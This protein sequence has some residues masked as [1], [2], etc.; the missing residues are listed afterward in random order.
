MLFCPTKHWAGS[1]FF[2]VL[3]LHA[4]AASGLTIY[5]IGGENFP[6]PDL[7]TPYEF[8]QI[9]WSDIDA[10]QHG[11][12]S[13]IQL[14]PNSIRPQ[15]LSPDIN[16]TP[17]IKE[18]GGEVL[19]F[20]WNGWHS[21][22]ELD[23]LM[24]DGD[25][26]TAFLGDGRFAVHWPYVKALTFDLGAPLLLD[27]I[28]FFPRDKH[29]TDR[30]LQ[31]FRI[32]VNDGDP[33][34][35]G[36]REVNLGATGFYFDFDIVYDVVENTQSVIDLTFP[37]QPIRYVLFYSKENTTG[38]WE[39]AEL[40]IYGNG[41]APFASYVSNVIDLGAPASLGSLR[42]AG[43]QDEGATLALSTRSGHDDDPNTYWR[44]TF[45]GGER[46]RFDAKGRPL[47][48]ASYN[49]LALGAQAG[50]THDTAGWT[51]W[52]T[53][54]DFAAGEG[55]IAGAG[56][57]Q[58]VQ[59]RADFTSG[60]RTS[61]QF[62]WVELAVSIPPVAQQ[63]VA[64]VMP[65][66]VPPGAATA[67]TYKVK[68]SIARDDLGFDRLAIDTPARV[69]S[70]DGVRL[71]GQPVAFD[72]V[73]SNDT[74]VV[75]AV[76][77]VDVQ[78]TQEVLE[79]AF[80]ASVFQFGTVF[81]GHIFNS[82][83]PSEVP[84]SLAWGDADGVPSSERLRVDLTGLG[85]GPLGGLSVEPRVFSPNGDRINDVVEIGC[86][87]L[88][89]SGMSSVAC[90]VYDVSGRRLGLV[91]ASRL[92]SGRYVGVWDG[93]DED[94]ALL[95]PGLYVVGLS[96]ETNQGMTQRQAVVSLVY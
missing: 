84:Q 67:F 91:D 89:L 77:L 32:G 53:A 3:L 6:P 11:R 60:Q 27:R 10:A 66:V 26:A 5:R 34:K 28:R 18:R 1:I 33:L 61:G 72:I 36:T 76:P 16:L 19:N 78:R 20:V 65:S 71:S 44:Y 23:E 49:K 88:N 13:L 7:D 92:G 58:F 45:R 62:D 40:E 48:L 86:D 8:V 50:F 29:L 80:H 85:T 87:V 21:P 30:F 12:E 69:Q 52:S 94:G 82:Q 15:F 68:A 2:A 17:L 93:R 42:W 75:L 4:P 95:S 38:I 70:V 25:L 51:F 64:E 31:Q 96:V 46:T 63:A 56:P 57:R 9:G 79:V 83:H 22:S 73:Q 14:D 81:T 43:Q 54:Q 47:N 41:F 37:D 55:A 24:F 35:D 39:I 90:W 74:G 59:V